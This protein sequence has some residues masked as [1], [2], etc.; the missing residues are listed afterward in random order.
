[1]RQFIDAAQEAPKLDRKAIREYAVARFGLEANA[2]LY[3]KYFNRLL[4]LWGKGFY[5]L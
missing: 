4:T 2:L 3:E 5:E 1:L